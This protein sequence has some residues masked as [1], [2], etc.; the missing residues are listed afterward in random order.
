MNA[1]QMLKDTVAAKNASDAAEKARKIAEQNFLDNSFAPVLNFWKS[2]VDKT[3]IKYD[4]KEQPLSRLCASNGYYKANL[5][6]WDGGGNYGWQYS[7]NGD[8]TIK[9][10]YGNKTEFFSISAEKAIQHLCSVI[11]TY[12]PTFKE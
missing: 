2:V 3:V 9:V 11:A 7:A 6:L 10:E 5:K 8:G 12:S 1:L 4:G